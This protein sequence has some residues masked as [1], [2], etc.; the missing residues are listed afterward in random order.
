MVDL[1]AE[2]ESR[3]STSTSESYREGKEANVRAADVEQMRLYDTLSHG[4]RPSFKGTESTTK[5]L[6]R[7][8]T[9]AALLP[10]TPKGSC[11]L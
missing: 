10:K 8:L 11:S 2:D 1:D 9:L 7:M 3:T 5:V 4:S 6:S